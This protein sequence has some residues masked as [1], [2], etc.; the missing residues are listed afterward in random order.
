[1]F[2]H[3]IECLVPKESAEDYRIYRMEKAGAFLHVFS[4]SYIMYATYDPGFLSRKNILGVS[5][6]QG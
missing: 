4:V 1:M 2:S 5:E 6:C 3:I